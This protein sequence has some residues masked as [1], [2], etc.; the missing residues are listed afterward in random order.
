MQNIPLNKDYLLTTDKLAIV[1]G[2]ID[3]YLK[4][5]YNNGIFDFIE[6]AR[7]YNAI[8]KEYDLEFNPVESIMLLLS[9]GFEHKKKS[10]IMLY[11]NILNVIKS[12]E[13]DMLAPLIEE[14]AKEEIDDDTYNEM[15]EKLPLF[16]KEDSEKV[17][18]V[19]ELINNILL[20][21]YSKRICRISS[22]ELQL[23]QQQVSRVA[24]V[25]DNYKVLSSAVIRSR[26]EKTNVETFELIK[27]SITEQQLEQVV[28]SLSDN[29][30]KYERLFKDK[31][32][33]LESDFTK[34][35]KD[36]SR[37]VLPRQSKLIVSPGRFF[38]LMGFDYKSFLGDEVGFGDKSRNLKQL[39]DLCGRE[40]KSK[41]EDLCDSY[42]KECAQFKSLTNYSHLTEEELNE[43]KRRAVSR[44]NDLYQIL[45]LII[46]NNDR[47]FQMLSEGR[48]NGII[49]VPKLTMK[50]YAFD[51]MRIITNSSG[52]LVFDKSI[53]MMHDKDVKTSNAIFLLNDI[54]KDNQL[55]FI[56]SEFKDR[57]S[58]FGEKNASSIFVGQ[59]PR[60]KNDEFYDQY[61]SVSSSASAYSPH[62]FNF[63]ISEVNE[64]EPTDY[65]KSG[66]GP[67]VTIN[68]SE[69][70]IY[71]TATSLLV[72]I[73]DIKN[74]DEIQKYALEAFK[75]IR[76]EG[77]R[78][79]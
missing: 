46:D 8:R 50:Q 21:V 64:N 58:L 53:A 18:S 74:K 51:R 17:A 43:L 36:K 77:G 19:L 5:N 38:H 9:E 44:G 55:S 59:K 15:Y 10:S 24:T 7:N 67:I 20:I 12:S 31:I 72:G 34:V 62:D 6:R 79:R 70:E 40:N 37:Y 3:K 75:K 52:I 29:V 33:V 26:D 68:Y 61:A 66:L 2:L 39:I 25:K 22:E 14:Y 45:M 41:I 71:N 16:G 60:F 78:S 56:F 76:S 47:L 73:P 27:S 42:L 32:W 63:S 11:E 48:L 54:I 28:Q 4:D 65:S 57:E 69:E 1:I 35:I 49:S 23:S 13:Y 30:D